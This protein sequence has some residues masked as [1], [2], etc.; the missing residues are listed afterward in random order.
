MISVEELLVPM[1]TGATQCMFGSSCAF[2]HHLPLEG[3][4]IVEPDSPDESVGGVPRPQVEPCQNRAVR[5]EYAGPPG[6]LMTTFA[7]TSALRG[8]SR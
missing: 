1:I 4:V 7:Q 5:R 3:I 2:G 8:P 6:A